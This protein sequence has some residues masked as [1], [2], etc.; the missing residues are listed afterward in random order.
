MT[1]IIIAITDKQFRNKPCNV[2]TKT[3]K[4]LKHMGSMKSF[5]YFTL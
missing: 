3:I 5:L 2:I 1:L 4:L